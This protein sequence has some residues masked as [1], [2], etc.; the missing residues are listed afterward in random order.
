[1]MSPEV[2]NQ[3][4]EIVT[5]TSLSTEQRAELL[6]PLMREHLD[7]ADDFDKACDAW[8]STMAAIVELFP[9]LRPH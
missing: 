8:N 2:I 6:V 1:M 3:M 9:E 4:I 5:N 7:D